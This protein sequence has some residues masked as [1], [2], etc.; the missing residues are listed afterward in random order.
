MGEQD[1][2]LRHRTVWD[3]RAITSRAAMQATP[4]GITQACTGFGAPSTSDRS[5]EDCL[6][7]RTETRRNACKGAPKHKD[8]GEESILHPVS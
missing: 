7:L 2:S 4:R 6:L 5:W 3:G 1:N 8:N